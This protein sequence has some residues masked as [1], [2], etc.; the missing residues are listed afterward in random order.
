VTAIVPQGLFMH[1]IVLEGV[2]DEI[3]DKACRA[4]SSPA[5]TWAELVS[6]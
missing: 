3:E 1:G 2:L 5:I 6:K 4:V